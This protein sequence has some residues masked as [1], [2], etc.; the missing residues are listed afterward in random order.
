[1]VIS[2]IQVSVG[3][4]VGPQFTSV[5]DSWSY[6]NTP[7]AKVGFSIGAF[8]DYRIH[9]SFKLRGGLYFD[10]RRFK[11]EDWNPVWEFQSGDS[12][13]VSY[14]SY[15]YK[16][17]IYNLNYLSIP[18]SIIYEKK[19]NKF[20]VYLQASV[21]YSLL[22]N[23]SR[24]GSTDLFID[25]EHAEYFEDKEK[26]KAGHTITSY[27]KEDVSTNFNSN[28]WGIQLY[29]GGIY[30]LN[31]RIGIHISPGFTMAFSNLYLNPQRTSRW[32]SVYKINAGIIYTLK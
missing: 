6:S 23:A 26:Y 28:D 25:P 12:V 17:F 9:K 29:I 21:Y 15:N 32:R 1:M 27:D 31:D 20:S 19:Y 8:V 24:T 2:K 5:Y 3:F 10:N 16:S 13:F 11:H 22:L 14:T 18:L 30:H 7:E 4:E